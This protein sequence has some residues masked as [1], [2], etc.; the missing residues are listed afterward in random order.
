[1]AGFTT[2]LGCVASW[3][4][5]AGTKVS[6]ARSI[7]QTALFLFIFFSSRELRINYVR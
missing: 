4:H 6:D 2:F 3:D 1:V 7:A 5:P